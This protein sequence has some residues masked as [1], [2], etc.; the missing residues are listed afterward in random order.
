MS[1][2]LTIRPIRAT[3][4]TLAKLELTRGLADEICAAMSVPAARFNAAS[5]EFRRRSKI[6]VP[7]DSAEL[8]LLIAE[9]EAAAG[10][11]ESM[12]AGEQVEDH[13]DEFFVDLVLMGL[14]RELRLVLV[15]LNAAFVQHT[16]PP[17]SRLD[18]LYLRLTWI[19]NVSTETFER[20]KY[21]S[22]SHEA[23]KA[24]NL[25][26]YISLMGHSWREETTADG[27]VLRK[28]Q[29]DP[30][31]E[32]RDRILDFPDT[33]YLLTLDADSLLLRDYCLRLVYFLESAGNERV[34]VTQT[35][36]SSFRGA[37]TRIERVAGATTDLQHI[38]HQ[39]M[40][41]YGATFWV[42]ANAI[43]RKSAL[44]DIVEVEASGAF[45]IR[46]VHPGPHGH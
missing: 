30:D 39:G 34:A 22:L 44:E 35:P 8:A 11:L 14:A 43:I 37:P 10:W 5:A 19:F 46:D 17:R 6:A 33:T 40:T 41:Y 12:A 3:R 28:V 18:E 45:E 4:R 31:L 42:G 27:V 16:S 24:M 26:A 21:A 9:Y 15:G 7:N 36:Y 23:N 32:G 2:C 13:V 29:G 25:N 20:K 38:L 1:C